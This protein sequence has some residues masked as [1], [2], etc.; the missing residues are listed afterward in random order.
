[1][2]GAN[3]RLQTTHAALHN[4]ARPGVALDQSAVEWQPAKATSQDANVSL[5]PTRRDF[6]GISY[7]VNSRVAME[8]L[9]ILAVTWVF[10]K[11]ASRWAALV[12]RMLKLPVFVVQLL[13]AMPMA[14][15]ERRSVPVA[16]LVPVKRDLRSDVVV[17]SNLQRRLRRLR[18][19]QRAI[20]KMIAWLFSPTR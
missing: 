13:R 1:M 12:Y 11:G 15:R 8:K 5:M 4:R 14:A 18:L 17:C 6:A 20:V 2:L 7:H 16:R 19:V 3:V 10:V 9:S